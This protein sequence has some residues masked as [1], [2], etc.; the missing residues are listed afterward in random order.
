LLSLATIGGFAATLPS[1]FTDEPVGGSWVEPVGLTFAHDGRMFVWEKAGKVWIVEN[2]I[3]LKQPLIDIHDEVGNW[4]DFGLVGFA[5]D[6]NFLSNGFIYLSYEV[7]HH[8]LINYG[9]P[10][11]NPN[12]NEYNRATTGKITR[13]T[14]KSSDGFRSVDP[15][16]RK[17]LLGEALNKGV[18]ILYTSHGVG[19]L[20]FGADVTLL[21]SCG[22]GSSLIP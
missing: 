17:I 6:P 3:R 4:G 16:S 12:V 19:S 10:N 22:E 15:A 7:D 18:P 2:G 13:Y 11:Y 1:G 8:H 20:V 14:A 9:T 21:A 5:L